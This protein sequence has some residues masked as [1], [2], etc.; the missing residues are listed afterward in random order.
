MASAASSARKRLIFFRRTVKLKKENRRRGEWNLGTNR[1]GAIILAAGKSKYMD[2]LKPMLRLGQTT[3]IQ[4]EID[5]L[6][7]AGLSPIVVVTG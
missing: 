4:R 5:T 2:E 7:T 6:R 3:M 1:T